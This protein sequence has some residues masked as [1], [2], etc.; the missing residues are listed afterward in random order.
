MEDFPAVNKI[1]GEGKK[2]NFE[3]FTTP[4]KIIKSLLIQLD[5]YFC[6]NM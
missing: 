5:G 1:Y 6:Y 3:K 4:N 2:K